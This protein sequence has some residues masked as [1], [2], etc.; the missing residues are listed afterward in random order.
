[1]LHTAQRIIGN[2]PTADRY[3][4]KLNEYKV[5][6][7]ALE[8]E[9]LKL[10]TEHNNFGFKKEGDAPFSTN[11]NGRAIGLNGDSEEHSSFSLD[12]LG[13]MN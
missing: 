5:I 11:G 2:T 10:F 8:D 6:L 4:E 1:M 3:M 13:S 7:N 12:D 9:N